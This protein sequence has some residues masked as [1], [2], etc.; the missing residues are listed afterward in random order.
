VDEYC[1]LTIDKFVDT[2]R[3]DNPEYALSKIPDVDAEYF[4]A[5]KKEV[6]ERHERLDNA[7]SSNYRQLM[8]EEEKKKAKPSVPKKKWWKLWE[9]TANA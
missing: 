3:E 1:D 8:E 2:I 4:E 5:L 6:L 7:K 9:N